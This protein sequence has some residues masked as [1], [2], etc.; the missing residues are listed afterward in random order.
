[1]HHPTIRL[2]VQDS[3]VL[4]KPFLTAKDDLQRRMGTVCSLHIS[5]ERLGWY[6][7]KQTGDNCWN[8]YKYLWHLMGFPGG[9]SGKEPACQ[10]RRHKRSR[11]N[12]W[13]GKIPWRAWQP[14]PVF[15][16]WESHGWRSLAVKR[17]TKSQTW[18][19][20]LS[21]HAWHWIAIIFLCESHF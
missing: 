2:E 18:L 11:F 21:M 20:R 13:V 10:G 6:N 7:Q 4:N 17:V 12:P 9:A 1:M 15:L 19:K 14:I 16:P 3:C 8:N 5:N